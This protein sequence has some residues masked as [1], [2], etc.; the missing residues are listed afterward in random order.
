LA[1]GEV[2][3]SAYDKPA[4]L[5]DEDGVAV[6][7]VPTVPFEKDAIALELAVTLEE[8]GGATFSGR[9]VYRG[10]RGAYRDAFSN[11]EEQQTS[12]ETSLA[13]IFAA[14]TI[15]AYDF[16]NIDNL[17]GDFAL[18]FEGRVPNFARVRGDKLAIRVAPYEFELGQVFISTDKRKYP[19]R[20]ERPEAWVDDVRIKLPA[21]YALEKV[22]APVRLRGPGAEYT[23]ELAV[24]GDT[25]IITRRL[26]IDQGDI[27]PGDYKKLVKFCREVDR[28]E[29]AEVTAVREPLS[30]AGG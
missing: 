8:G 27:S 28:R 15:T 7:R 18:R 25:L 23:L 21:G 20:I 30:P 16:E 14:A 13:Q 29:R 12:V 5:V 11:P 26:F 19:L 9:R 6:G 3:T 4:L 22:G 17:A 2:W 24:E 10:L 1:F